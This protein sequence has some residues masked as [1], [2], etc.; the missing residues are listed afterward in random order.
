MLSLFRLS[1]EQYQVLA[2]SPPTQEPL[3]TETFSLWADTER[4]TDFSEVSPDWL[5]TL[6]V[7]EIAQSSLHLA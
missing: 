2:E 7:L 5:L 4:E 3:L 6:L 1:G